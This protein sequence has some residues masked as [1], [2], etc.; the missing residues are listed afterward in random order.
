MGGMIALQWVLIISGTMELTEPFAIG[1]GGSNVANKKLHVDGGMTIGSGYDSTAV[2]ANSL[3]VQG[4]ITSGAIT[5]SGL[6]NLG[7]TGSLGSITTNQNIMANFNGGYS[8]PTKQFYAKTYGSSVVSTV[9]GSSITN[10]SIVATAGSSSAGLLLGTLTADPLIIGTSNAAKITIP[11]SGDIAFHS[12]NATFTGTINSGAIT[13][14]G[15][16]RCWRFRHGCCTKYTK[17]KHI[18]ERICFN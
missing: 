15:L 9:F 10:K 17:S 13:S 16:N 6:L 14:T 4:T 3:N 1:G 18:L 12:H 11:A 8:S 5:S 7:G 2:T